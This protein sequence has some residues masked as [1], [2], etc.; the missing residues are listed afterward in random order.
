MVRGCFGFTDSRKNFFFRRANAYFFS[1]MPSTYANATY[2]TLDAAVRARYPIDDVWDDKT[3]KVTAAHAFRIVRTGVKKLMLIV[4]RDRSRK[5]VRLACVDPRVGCVL[6]KMLV[7]QAATKEEL[8]ARCAPAEPADVAR[9]RRS[10]AGVR[11]ALAVW[12]MRGHQAP[13]TERLPPPPPLPFP[14]LADLRAA[15]QKQG[16]EGEET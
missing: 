15:L 6:Y 5:P 13:P 2:A 3:R 12:E 8:S 16:E 7:E 4:D 11:E 10:I 9:Y 1:T 14:H